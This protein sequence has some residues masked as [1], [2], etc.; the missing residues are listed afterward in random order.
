MLSGD[1]EPPPCP[2]LPAV[3]QTIHVLPGDFLYSGTY[4]RGCAPLHLRITHVPAGAERT[5]TQWV[6]L[7]GVEIDPSGRDGQHRNV[8]VRRS[9]LT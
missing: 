3:G 4:E 1:I 8:V 5:T 7:L 9:A 6:A 2:H